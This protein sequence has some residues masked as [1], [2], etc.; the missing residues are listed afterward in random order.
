MIAIVGRLAIMDALLDLAVTLATLAFYAALRPRSDRLFG[1]PWLLAWTAMAAGVLAKGP[2]AILATALVI[3]PWLIWERSRDAAGLR[4]PT[5]ANW[6]AGLSAFALIAVPW[7]VA[8]AHA[9]GTA[10]VGELLG[11]YS[12]GRYLGTIE[13]Q[14]GPV[15]YYLPVIVLGFFPWFAFLL[16][17][18]W[19][20][21]RVA[22]EVETIAGVRPELA[23]LVLVWAIVPLAFFSFAQ[24]KLPNY[25]ALEFPAL[26]IGVGIW[27]DAVCA[28][29]DRRWAL[30][31]T[32]LVPA[33]IAG[34]AFAM[35][36]FSRNMHLGTDVHKVFGDLVVLAVVVRAGSI[37]CFALL[38]F[39]AGA[40]F[41][42]YALAA[43]TVGSLLV[44]ALVAE[45]HTEAF[46]PIP[47]LARVIV[48]RRVAGDTVAI[49]GVAGQNA[50]VFY[51]EPR[52]E[53]IDGSSDAGR[54]AA[55][56][57]EHAI[58]RPGR[59]FVVAARTRPS[60]DPTFGRSRHT[61]AVAD[62]DALFLYD[63]PPCAPAD[64]RPR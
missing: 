43:A 12:V 39:R 19:H 53:T 42:P 49:E 30:A 37:G 55:G 27:F 7:F 38:L 25:V 17:A 59:T 62:G 61:L 3:F 35:S 6:C 34:V 21:G 56:G 20:Q 15:W 57:P 16:P 51:T 64:G 46:K 1:A 50:L 23:R 14:T 44:V 9:A 54:D 52:V 36:V 33:S 47:S 40:P 5:L 18:L 13:N 2:I 58:C 11:H 8:L 48:E 10:T 45:P 22:F 28:S 29:A 24:T 41:A 32:A 63:G 26:A 31:W 60:P 4:A